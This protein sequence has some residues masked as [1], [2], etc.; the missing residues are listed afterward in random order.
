MSV[1]DNIWE[2]SESVLDVAVDAA[3]EGY[4]ASR[5]PAPQPQP[6][7]P[8]P[9]QTVTRTAA[10]KS[11]R[12]RTALERAAGAIEP[13]RTYLPWVLIGLIGLWVFVRRGR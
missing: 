9:E 10:D 8:M 6:Q 5:T 1:W 2:K 4:V 7:Q 3:A 13:Y 12:S 11:D